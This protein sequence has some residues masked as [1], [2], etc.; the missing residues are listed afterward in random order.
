II[1]TILS[2]CQ[3]FDF[4]RIEIKDIVAH[5]ASIAQTEGVVIE[6]EALHI[7]AQKADGALRDALSIFDQIVSFCGNN[8]TYADVIENLNVLDYDYYFKLTDGIFSSDLAT[9]LVIFD[10]ILYKGFDGHNFIVGMAAHF[11][12]LLVCKNKATLKLLEVSE[13]VKEKY[14]NQAQAIPNQFLTQALQIC[15]QADVNYK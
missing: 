11:R 14:F 1:P 3:I 12:N 5:L 15:S 2:R 7:I 13:G 10:E 4:K 8:V 6:D 9:A